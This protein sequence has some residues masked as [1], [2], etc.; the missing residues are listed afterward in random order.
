MHTPHRTHT[1][2]KLQRSFL[3]L[4][5]A[6]IKEARPNPVVSEIDVLI[7][8]LNMYNKDASMSNLGNPKYV[9]LTPEASLDMETTVLGISMVT[10]KINEA[11][12]SLTPLPCTYI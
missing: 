7:G 9:K 10:M 12:Y 5:S 8:S 4:P 2:L 1:G 6:G 11:S 3:C